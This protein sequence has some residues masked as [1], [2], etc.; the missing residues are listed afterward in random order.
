MRFACP[1]HTSRSNDGNLSHYCS[2]NL[3]SQEWHFKIKNHRQCHFAWCICRHFC[4]V[5]TTSD[6]FGPLAARKTMHR[7]IPDFTSKDDFLTNLVSGQQSLLNFKR[8]RER[9]PLKV[10]VERALCSRQ[11]LL[12]AKSDAG[13]PSFDG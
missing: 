8:E 7:P 10:A 5:P 4:T 1:A 13:P 6:H 12:S 9:Q 2:K 3:F 11:M